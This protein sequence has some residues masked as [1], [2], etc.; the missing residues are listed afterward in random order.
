MRDARRPTRRS[1]AAAALVG[2]AP[3]FAALGDE[4]RLRIVAQLCHLGPLSIVRL[5]EGTQVSR[6]AVTKHLLALQG[7]GLVRSGRAGRERRWELRPQPLTEAQGYL[8]QISSQWDSALARLKQM[9]ESPV[10]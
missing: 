7:V 8:T 1:A 2:A 6:Q 10:H 5:T 9:M 3:L 4:T